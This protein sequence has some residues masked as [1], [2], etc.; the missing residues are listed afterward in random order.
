MVPST[1]FLLVVIFLV[2]ALLVLSYEM[3]YSQRAGDDLPEESIT[4]PP[5]Q[6]PFK[7]L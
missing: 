1:E 5:A 3:R 2:I 6:Q 4:R 7:E